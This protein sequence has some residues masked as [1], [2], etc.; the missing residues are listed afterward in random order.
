MS[1]GLQKAGNMLHPITSQN[2]K[3]Y[4]LVIQ[5]TEIEVGVETI[6]YAW[7]FNG[8]VQGP[9]LKARTGE[10]VRITVINNHN[11]THSS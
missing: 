8:T 9:T 7:T 11:I 1:Q 6:W 3:E 4:T 5:G 10:T 2:V